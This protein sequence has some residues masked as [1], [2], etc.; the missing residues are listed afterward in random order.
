MGSGMCIDFVFR[1][2]GV[3]LFCL[4]ADFYVVISNWWYGFVTVVC[5]WVSVVLSF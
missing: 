3:V 4:R 1:G 5:D 2:C